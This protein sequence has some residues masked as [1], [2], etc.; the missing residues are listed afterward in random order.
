MPPSELLAEASTPG[1]VS[2]E[3]LFALDQYAFQAAIKEAIERGAQKGQ[4][5]LR[6]ILIS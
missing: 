5:I 6:I 1:G 4:R 2:V 3:C